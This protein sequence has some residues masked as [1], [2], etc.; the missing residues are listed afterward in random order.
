MY[1]RRRKGTYVVYKR[2][3]ISIEIILT[4][5]LQEFTF[6]SLDK[7]LFP[8]YACSASRVCLGNCNSGKGKEERV[9]AFD[10]EINESP[11]YF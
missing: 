11:G 3:R 10:S 8:G 5:K 2:N 4:T 9:N 6:F 7:E 1:R